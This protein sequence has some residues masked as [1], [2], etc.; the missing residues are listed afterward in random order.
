MESEKRTTM[1][2]EN[3]LDKDNFEF[4][5]RLRLELTREFGQQD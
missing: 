2:H 3:E 5:E 1:T 4:K